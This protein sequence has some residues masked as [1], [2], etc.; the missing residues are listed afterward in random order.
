MAGKITALRLQKRSKR[1]VNVYL[2]GEFAFGLADIAAYPLRVGEWLS[3]EKIANLQ[4]TDTLEQARDKALSYLAYR[5][6]S[7]Y[8]LQRYLSKREF[9]E[10]IVSQVLAHLQAVGLVDD[11]AFARYWIENRSQFRPRGALT[12]RQELRQKGLAGAIIDEALE[13]YDELAALQQAARKH[14]RRLRQ[15]PAEKFRQR[16]TQRLVRRGFSYEN[17]RDIIT[18]SIIQSEGDL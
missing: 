7:I 13:D 17:I 11:L 4:E 8:E 5:P 9:P 15:L 3:D 6:R 18:D 2:D 10:P 16:L 14:A 1:R 12:L